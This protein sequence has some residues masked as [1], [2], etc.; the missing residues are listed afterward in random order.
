M[1]V[2]ARD[3]PTL[4]QLEAYSS[5]LALVPDVSGKICIPP[6]PIECLDKAKTCSK[7]FQSEQKFV[8][9]VRLR[10]A[11]YP[12]GY[13]VIH[14][15][16]TNWLQRLENTGTLA[17]TAAL[18]RTSA[19]S[20]FANKFKHRFRA[21]C[22]DDAKAN[23]AA[24]A[25]MLAFRNLLKKG[26]Q[27][28]RV[29]CEVHKAATCHTTAFTLLEATISGL[30]NASLSVNFG[31]HVGRFRRFMYEVIKANIIFRN[32]PLDEQAKTYKMHVLRIFCQ[33]GRKRS[34][35]ITMLLR[36]LPGPLGPL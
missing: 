24:E 6:L 19:V 8:A 13:A 9:L 16:S 4:Q 23:P 22:T 25:R 20:E 14:G 15:N 7:L 31:S 21:A 18:Q 11:G 29:A 35:R 12:A 36:L 5:E 30:L 1:P 3:L 33:S 26:W 17:V 2:L 27:G 10:K 28:W 32:T 34:F